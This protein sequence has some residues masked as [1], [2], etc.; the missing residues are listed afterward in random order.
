VPKSFQPDFCLGA[1]I[2]LKNCQNFI[3]DSQ[4]LSSS[5]NSSTILKLESRYFAW[6]QFKSNITFNTL[7]YKT[8]R[9]VKYGGFPRLQAEKTEKYFF[10]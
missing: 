10:I 2:W 9:K 4:L 3:S 7:Y 6:T 8:K 5:F 1:E